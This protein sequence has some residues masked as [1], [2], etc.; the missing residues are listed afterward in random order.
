MSLKDHYRLL[1]TNEAKF[2]LR[3]GQI[4]DAGCF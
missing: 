2:P 3:S 4:Y 1:T